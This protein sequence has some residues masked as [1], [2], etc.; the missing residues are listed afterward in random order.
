MNESEVLRSFPD[1][2]A[3]VATTGE[4][5][6]PGRWFQIDADRVKLFADATED[7]QWIHVDGQRAESG[8]FG[9]AIAHGYLTLALIPRLGR[10]LFQVLGT[11]MAINYGLERV[12][13]PQPVP[14]GSR[15]RATARLLEAAAVEAGVRVTVR[16][17]V[18]L[19]GG[20][21]PVCV[22]DAI[23]LLVPEGN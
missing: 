20:T 3:F 13:F 5:I 21:K 1:V 6:G 23:S 14:V 4:T 12:R 19:E 16:Y 11:R 15:V 22:A 10:G 17:A 7:R 2:A 9:R 8:P 18:E